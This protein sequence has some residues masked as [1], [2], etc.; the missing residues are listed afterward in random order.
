MYIY[1]PVYNFYSI[2]LYIKLHSKLQS[3]LNKIQNSITL[4]SSLND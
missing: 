1:K 2:T 3:D 4:K